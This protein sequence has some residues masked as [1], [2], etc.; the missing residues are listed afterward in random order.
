MFSENSELWEF[1]IS[2]NLYVDK[3]V[4][5]AIEAAEAVL[6][7]LLLF[8][9]EQVLFKDDSYVIWFSGP[10]VSTSDTGS[11]RGKGEKQELDVGDLRSK[12]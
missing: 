10:L 9:L 8:W 5:E 1:L 6:E 2:L 4:V 3:S 12:L 11:S 7:A